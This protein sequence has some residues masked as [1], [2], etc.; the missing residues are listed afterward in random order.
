MTAEDAPPTYPASPYAEPPQIAIVH[1]SRTFDAPRERV[2]RAWTDPAAVTRWFGGPGGS[3]K[4]V[5]ADVRVGGNYRI[6]MKVRPTGRKAYVVGTY[7]EIDPPERLVYTFA[8]EK[9]PVPT[10][11]MGDSKVTVDFRELGAATEV[12][13]TH[14][15]LDKG[16][17]RAFHRFGWKTSM[18]RLARVL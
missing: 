13:L 11:G 16:R 12:S 5:E 1:V 14:E 4:S 6:T 3:T 18:E 15:L 17:L 9:L 7:L 8:W 2:F 10:F